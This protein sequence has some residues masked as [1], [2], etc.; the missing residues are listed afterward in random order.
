MSKQKIGKQN[1][2]RN[3]KETTDRMIR[4]NHAGEFGASCIYQGQLSVLAKSSVGKTIQHM[5]DQEK[6]HLETFDKLI[7]ERR[8]RPTALSPIW[9]LAGYSLGVLTARMGKKAA[10]ACTV[11]VE[12]VI[13]EH[14]KSQHETLGDKDPELSIII[15]K[16]RLDEIEHK[17]ISNNFINLNKSSEA[18]QDENIYPLM[19]KAIKAG[20]KLAIWLSSR[21]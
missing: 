21:L 3:I 17:S 7:I 5:A 1:S 14:Y 2:D 13:E 4:V 18:E 20:S 19:S 10:M 16:F 12:E 8:I 15:D 9:S 11:A 6:D